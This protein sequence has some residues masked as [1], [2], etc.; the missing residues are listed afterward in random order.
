MM[1]MMTMMSLVVLVRP[2]GAGGLR[3]APAARRTQE[4]AQGEEGGAGGRQ[5]DLGEVEEV[6]SPAPR[7]GG[8]SPAGD[9]HLLP[10]KFPISS[11]GSFGWSEWSIWKMIK[12]F[13]VR[14]F[15]LE[16][17]EAKTQ[18]QMKLKLQVET[19]KKNHHLIL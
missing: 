17:D 8:R 6:L 12:M 3:E 5:R 13:Y 10:A 19:L 9:R 18:N 4:Q 16:P 7:P 14:Y 1:M 2:G 11:Q 15:C